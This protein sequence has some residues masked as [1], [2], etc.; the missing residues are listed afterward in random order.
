MSIKVQFRR[1]NTTQTSAFTGAVAE[2][3]VNTDNNTLV[4]QDGV[5]AGGWPTPTL[6]FTQAAFNVANAA[7]TGTFTQAAFNQ[8]NTATTI[9]QSGYDFANT[10]NTYSYSSYSTANSA[11]ANTIVSQGVD[12][13]QNSW[14]SS[15]AAYSQSAYAF[16]NTVNSYA[17]SANTFLQ[18]NDT[19]TLISAKSYTDTANTFLRANDTTTLI[20]AKSY[21][22]TANTFLQANDATTLAS[23]KS[24]TDTANTFLQANDA[25]TLASAKSY[26]DT[27]NTFLRANDT[28]TL[29]SAKSYTDTAN[30]S[31]KAYGDATYFAKSGGTIS[32]AVTIQN[33]LTVTGNIT[34]T[35]NATSQVITGNTGQ[36]FGYAANGFNALYAGIPTGYLIEPQIIT[37]F[38][39]NYN[40]Y[41]GVNHQ[42]I[43]SGANSSSDIFITADNGTANDGYV[44]IGMGSSTYNYP[45]FNII[46]PNDGY[47]LVYGNTTTGGGN[48]I[49]MTGLTNDIVFAANGTSDSNVV[50]RVSGLGNNVIIKSTVNSVS[51]TTGA[52]IINGGLGVAGNVY[53]GNL[54]SFGT[55]I[56]SYIGAAYNKANGAVQTGFTTITANGAS[57]TPASNTDTLTITSAAANG[58]N[59][60]NPSSKT[61]DFGLRTTGVVSGAYGNT[62]SIPTITVDSFGRITSVSNNSITVPPGTTIIANTGQ[63][64]ANASTGNVALGLATS[65][66]TAGTYGNT[67]NIPVITVDT[68]G[69]ITSVSNTA[70]TGGGGGSATGLSLTDGTQISDANATYTTTT[71]NQVL[72]IFSTTSYRSVKYLIQAVYGVDVHLTNVL[73]T[74]ND[75][76]V[77]ITEFGTIYS[78]SPLISIDADLTAGNVSLYVTP[79]FSAQ[80]TIDFVKTSLIGRTLPGGPVGDLM[81]FTTGSEDLQAESGSFSLA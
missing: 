42:N 53:A 25:T 35:G 72:D 40:G 60:L 14:I 16:A 1:G 36:F 44:D 19:T 71:A 67:T 6:A 54:Y 49:M 50:M 47:F 68:Y 20:S 33:N 79:A 12:A 39:A 27:A 34:F 57:I 75:V 9:A 48:L 29:I 61:I 31:L 8:A 5:T 21:T 69:R 51:N 13:T 81:A 46:K 41:A 4:V 32:G 18:A 15:N 62:T 38:T 58:I 59:I 70:V 65:G 23:A 52:L 77:Y 11:Q 64:T 66:V 63:L 7:G 2:V 74:H 10:V 80:T 28:T 30:T 24:Y 17:Y 45:G 76:S 55:N 43:N 73:L 22:D 26:T 3:T 37:Q 56:V 78:G